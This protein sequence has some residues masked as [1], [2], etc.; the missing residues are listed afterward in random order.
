MDGVVTSGLGEG[1]FFMSLGYYKEEIRKKLG[2]DAYPGTLNLKV[3]K[4]QLDSLKQLTPI[5]IPSYKENNAKFGGVK[6]YKA[7]I[8]G[9]GGF[10]IIPDINKHKKNIIEFIT[11]EH[12]KSKL[13]IKDG[14]K[15]KI[16]LTE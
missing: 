12:I 6:C 5:I 9:I 7:E 2:I 10:I 1:A 3:N 11:P 13:K 14:D 16:E 15:I 4:K 8:N